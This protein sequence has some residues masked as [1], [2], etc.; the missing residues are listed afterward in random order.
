MRIANDT[1]ASIIRPLSSVEKTPVRP[2]SNEYTLSGRVKTEGTLLEKLR[3]MKT[4]PIMNVQDVAG[5]R[6]DCDLSL[7]EQLAIA[8]AFGNDFRQAGATRVDI[9]DFRKQPHSGYRAVHLHIRAKAGRGE[10]Q[11]RT[12]LQAKWANIYEEAADIVGRDIRYLHEGATLPKGAEPIV[13]KLHD[14]SSMV[15]RVEELEDISGFKKSDEVRALYAEVYGMLD[16]IHDD[17]RG[18]RSTQT[19]R[20]GK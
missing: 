7:T 11:I 9:R 10:M 6:F 18:R 3:R 17:L 2:N 15:K 16:V 12:A 5:F 20:E 1:V 19:D 4:T 13:N 8:E 14:A